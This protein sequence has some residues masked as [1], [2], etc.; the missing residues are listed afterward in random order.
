MTKKRAKIINLL[1]EEANAST[2]STTANNENDAQSDAFK[3]A[4]SSPQGSQDLVSYHYHT[5]TII[6]FPSLSLFTNKTPYNK[7]TR[8]SDYRGTHANGIGDH[9]LVFDQQFASQ[10]ESNLLTLVQ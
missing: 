1:N 5:H 2:S 3:S 4:S 8:S 10:F 9:K 6:K 7:A